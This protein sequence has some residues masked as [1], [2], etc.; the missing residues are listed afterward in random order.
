MT[1]AT[2]IALVERSVRFPVPVKWIATHK[3]V[4]FDEILAVFLLWNFSGAEKL[5]PGGNDAKVRFW[6]AGRE[7]PDGRR[8]SKTWIKKHR[9]LPIGVGGSLFDEHP[10]P[11][12]PR[13][14]A[15]ECAATLVAKA[16]GLDQRPELQSLL[17]FARRVNN[18]ATAD[19]HD[20][21]S[22]IKLLHKHGQMKIGEIVRFAHQGIYAKFC[23]SLQVEEAERNN[24][25]VEHIAEL[26]KKQGLDDPYSPEAWLGVAT[27]VLELDQV[28]FHVVVAEAYQQGKTLIPFKGIGRGGKVKEMKIA[29]I[30]TNLDVHAYARYADKVAVT[31]QMNEKGQVVVMSN[32]WEGIR[33]YDVIKAI[34]VEECLLR[35]ETPPRWQELREELQHGVWYYHV[36]GQ[37]LFNGSK[38]SPDT[39]PTLI[40]LDRI[41]QLVK[42]ALSVEEFEPFHAGRCQEGQCTSSTHQPCPWYSW[43]LSRCQTIRFYE[44]G[45]V[46]AVSQ[47]K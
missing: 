20:I 17:Q 8:A 45:E 12:Q 37:N 6:N 24:F 38:T 43:G 13:S 28:A 5:F 15:Q 11:G 31:I 2:F 41:A 44:R 33:M 3:W 47:A 29:V 10:L 25:S 36:P 27:S 19:P 1:A 26:M 22:V 42:L 18:T 9:T 34:V 14:E 4:D 23:E 16:T 46:A 21:S 35:G 30:R 7:T 32:K 40:P 39:E